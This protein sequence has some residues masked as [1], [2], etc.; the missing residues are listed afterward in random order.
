LALFVR[1]RAKIR[2]LKEAICNIE[3]RNRKFGNIGMG[4]NY[5]NLK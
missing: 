3:E 5:L 2:A 4:C 1:H